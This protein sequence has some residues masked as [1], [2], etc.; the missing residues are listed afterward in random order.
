M[1]KEAKIDSHTLPDTLSHYEDV[2]MFRI[3]PRIYLIAFMSTYVKRLRYLEPLALF[4]GL[5]PPSGISCH[6]QVV[7][8]QIKTFV[9][10]KQLFASVEG[11]PKLVNLG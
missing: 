8:E 7:R 5:K 11:Q 9:S 1:G 6:W 3:Y 2:L 10:V 4:L